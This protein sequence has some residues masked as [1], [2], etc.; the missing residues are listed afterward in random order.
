MRIRFEYKGVGE[1]KNLQDVFVSYINN[2]LPE[3]NSHTNERCEYSIS[4][5][6]GGE[7]ISNNIT[8]FNGIAYFF[9]TVPTYNTNFLAIIRKGI[10]NNLNKIGGVLQYDKCCYINDTFNSNY[11]YISTISP[12]INR[13]K[14][15]PISIDDPNYLNILN[16]NTI[17]KLEEVSNKYNLNLNLKNFKIEF[18]TD[19]LNR[20]KNHNK[21]TFYK[22]VKLLGGMCMLKITTNSDVMSILY[23]LGLG[24]STGIGFGAIYMTNNYSNHFK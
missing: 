17:N 4:S 11:V 2:S 12:I 9:V 24:M 10:K 7:K 19:K 18:A 23:G 3:N 8:K 16:K 1:I 20:N 21:T 14:K 6:I 5:L 22:G 15:V 13:S